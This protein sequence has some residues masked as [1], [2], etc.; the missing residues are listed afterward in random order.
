VRTRTAVCSRKPSIFYMLSSILIF[1]TQHDS[2]YQT[3]FISSKTSSIY[4]GIY[5]LFLISL[6]HYTN[7]SQKITH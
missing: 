4:Q 7:K 1:I 3:V 5:E 6:H 2:N